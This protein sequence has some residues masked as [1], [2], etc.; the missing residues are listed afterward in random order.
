MK[1]QELQ[2]LHESVGL[3]DQVRQSLIRAGWTESVDN[4]PKG[5]TFTISRAENG[6]QFN[7]SVIDSR[8]GVDEPGQASSRVLTRLLDPMFR[9]ARQTGAT[10]TQPVGASG[11]GWENDRLA[12]RVMQFV[13]GQ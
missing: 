7:V 8:Q 4:V 1:L 11:T 10:F 2:E 9:Q 3:V 5:A 6:T 13:V 12:G